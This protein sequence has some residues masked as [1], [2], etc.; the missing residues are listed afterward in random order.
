MLILK[1]MSN[2]LIIHLNLIFSNHFLIFFVFLHNVILSV[3]LGYFYWYFDDRRF[4]GNA[5][6]IVK[7]DDD[8]KISMDGIQ[9]T[10]SRKY[11]NGNVPDI[12]E[13]PSGRQHL[14]KNQFKCIYVKLFQIYSV[15]GIYSKD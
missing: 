2:H 5:N 14:E 10:L 15:K 9:R 11:G 6:Y 8:V 3:S 12:I 1:A 4:C 7:I 13:C